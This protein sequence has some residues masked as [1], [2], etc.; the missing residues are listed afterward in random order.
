MAQGLYPGGPSLNQ[1]GPVYR[2]GPAP[3]PYGP[4]YVYGRPYPYPYP[5]A[6]RPYPRV[7]YRPY[8]MAGGVYYWR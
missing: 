1:R 6:Y 8:F 3:Y 2:R 4:R 7:F 5:Y